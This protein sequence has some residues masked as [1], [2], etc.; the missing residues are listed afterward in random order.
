MGMSRSSSESKTSL[1]SRHSRYSTSS[2]RA[3]IR[4]LGCW[5]PVSMS[6]VWSRNFDNIAPI[7]SA[8][9]ALSNEYTLFFMGF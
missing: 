8:D 2:S 3:T 7:L 9:E 1:H 4:T 5:Q 6:G